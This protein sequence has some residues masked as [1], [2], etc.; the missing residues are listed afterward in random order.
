MN[1]I[2]R[3]AAVAALAYFYDHRERQL[4]KRL[5][6]SFHDHYDLSVASLHMHLD[7]DSCLEVAALKGAIRDVRNFARHVI[8]E[9]GV[10]TPGYRSRRIREPEARTGPSRAGAT[11]MFM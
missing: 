7:H 2:P 11:C 9:R 1:V 8:A 3:N 6:G 4:A 5:T 10:R